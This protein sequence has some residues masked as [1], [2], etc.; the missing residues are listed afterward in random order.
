MTTHT[1]PPR[2]PIAD[3]ATIAALRDL[4]AALVGRTALLERKIAD[5]DQRHVVE[6]ANAELWGIMRVLQAANALRTYPDQPAGE[7]PG[8]NMGVVQWQHLAHEGYAMMRELLVATDRLAGQPWSTT[9]AIPSPS[10]LLLALQNCRA[11]ALAKVNNPARRGDWADVLRFCSAAGVSGSIL[12]DAQAAAQAIA[13]PLEAPPKRYFRVEG[14]PTWVLVAA[15]ARD[16]WRQWLA[17]HEA[18][19]DS[20]MEGDFGLREM[21]GAEVDNAMVDDD[22]QQRRLADVALGSTFCSEY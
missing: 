18:C 8:Y 17:W 13:T 6:R 19:G 22:G 14:G 12:R 11:L 1:I 7:P 16:A 4:H 9:Q 2:D 3:E 5:A 15:T 10:Q 21:T 20:D